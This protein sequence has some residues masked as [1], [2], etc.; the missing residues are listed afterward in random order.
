MASIIAVAALAMLM[1]SFAVDVQWLL[2]PGKR[3]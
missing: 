2:R 3:Y 1:S